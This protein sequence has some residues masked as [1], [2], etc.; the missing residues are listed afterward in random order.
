[1]GRDRREYN[2]EK[3]IIWP[4][5]CAVPGFILGAERRGL[6]CRLRSFQK[7]ACEVLFDDRNKLRAKIRRSD[8]IGISWRA[9]VSPKRGKIELNG[10][11]GENELVTIEVW[12]KSYR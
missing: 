2:D 3:G 10:G 11:W 12:S 7:P 5:R 4:K 6:D 1:M 8:L 9:V